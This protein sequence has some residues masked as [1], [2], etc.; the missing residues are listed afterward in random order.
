MGATRT[1]ALKR[2]LHIGETIVIAA[3]VMAMVAVHLMFYFWPFRYR[4]AHPLMEKVFQSRVDVKSYHRTY[5]PHPGFVAEGVTLY[6]HGDTSIPTLAT[7][8]RMEVVGQWTRLIFHPHTLYQIRLTGLHVQIPPPGTSARGMD[9]DN[10]VIGTD[11]SKLR[12][13]T[14]V[15]DGTTLDFLRHS[16][17]PLRYVFTKLVIHNVQDKHPLDFSLRVMTSEPQGTVV[18]A[19][20]LGP[21]R[22]SSY[23][24]T[25]MSGSYSRLDGNLNGFGGMRGHA[26]GSGRFSG[27]FSRIDVKGWAKSPDF[28]VGSGHPVGMDLDYFVTVNGTNGDVE[29]ENAV[30][31]SGK[32]TIT[33]SGSVAGTPKKAAITIATKDSDVADLL[34]IVER[35]PPQVEGLLNFQAAVEFGEEPGRFLRKLSLKGDA[36]VDDL[37]LVN[38][39]KQEK[40]DA[41]SARVRKDP[42]GA[43][44]GAGDG[45]EAG[46][47]GGSR[48]DPPQITVAAKSKTSFDHG[49]AYFPDIRASMPGA[50]ARL[51]GTFNLLDTRIHL[52]G[53]VALERGLSHA[54]TGWKALLLKPVS[55]FFRH[56]D[57]GAVVAVAI[58][59][60]TQKPKIGEDVLHDK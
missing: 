48:S 44:A 13:E 8:E 19:G 31:R 45:P 10:G 29:I 39:E 37:R 43:G 2:E 21:F 7:I 32:S 53:Q 40:V 36:S 41:F 24:T 59:G 9:F 38:A 28:Q 57:A 49:I 54:V 51:H 5:F 47:G 22:T 52:T 27:I 46:S 23:G 33:A 25:P 6:R 15:A 4:Q 60:T 20:R 16:G 56:K 18:G 17:A 14:I 35:E 3:F 34:K 1:T 26:V 55:P 50:R 11:E 12:I 42:P 58:T 30:V